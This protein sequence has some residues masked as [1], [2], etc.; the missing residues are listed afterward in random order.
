MSDFWQGPGWWLASDGKWYPADAEP[1]GD[2]AA[3]SSD[4][5]AA[6]ASVAPADE[7]VATSAPAASTAVAVDDHGPVD[8]E[9]VDDEAVVDLNEDASEEA[10]AGNDALEIDTG[11]GWQAIDSTSEDGYDVSAPNGYGI[12][13]AEESVEDATDEGT[14]AAPTAQDIFT[15]SPEAEADGGPGGWEPSEEALGVVDGDG[16]PA[17]PVLPTDLIRTDPVPIERDD[18]WRKPVGEPLVPSSMSPAGTPHV[19]DV[20]VTDEPDPTPETA[21]SSR[22]IGGYILVV[23]LVVSIVAL[24]ALIGWL[25]T[26]VNDGDDTA[27]I[28]ATTAAPQTEDGGDAGQTAQSPTDDASSSTAPE[29][30]DDVSVF[31]LETGDCIKDEIGEGQVQALVAV[32]CS[33]PH[34]FEV[35]RQADLTTDITE[36]DLDAITAEGER[37]CA[38]SFDN[39]IPP[40]DERNLRFKWLQPTPDSWALEGEEQD[41]LITCLLFDE[42]GPLTGRVAE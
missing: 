34:S 35:F 42:D 6:A 25:F 32:D 15:D 7:Q 28:P 26:R 19:V 40:G 17:P 11:S 27:T 13:A 3:V 8:D 41:R 23:A 30:D 2:D 24:A 18:A 12:S 33:E 1:P 39:A 36:F 22:P 9:A 29:G 38:E 20:T 16:T 31:S 37:I 4:D 14:N 5:S 10:E 21:P